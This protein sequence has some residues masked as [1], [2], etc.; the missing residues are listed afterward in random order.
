[1][2]VGSVIELVAVLDDALKLVT[3]AVEETETGQWQVSFFDV[4][5]GWIDPDKKKLR[6]LA[7]LGDGQAAQSET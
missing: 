3:V 6:R 2:F 5:I 7:A 4:P 1:M